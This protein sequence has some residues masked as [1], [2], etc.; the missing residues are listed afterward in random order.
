MTRNI[1]LGMVAGLL[2]VSIALGALLVRTNGEVTAVKGLLGQ[3]QV[4]Q[5]KVQGQLKKSQ[6]DLALVEG[7]FDQAKVDLSTLQQKLTEAGATEKDLKLANTQLSKDLAQKNNDYDALSKNYGT[8][9]KT[10]TANATQLRKL[11]CED[12]SLNMDYSTRSNIAISLQKYISTRPY[13]K[14]ASFVVPGQLW[15]NTTTQ[16][17]MVTYVNKDDSKV[18]GEV[19]IVFAREFDMIPATFDVGHQCW[20]DAP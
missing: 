6:D 19:Y 20:V 18:Y 8:L 13:V 14:S 7:K 15:N 10:N 1:L 4:E 16:Y 9:D 5:S 2:I 3:A 11:L 17:Y 12:V